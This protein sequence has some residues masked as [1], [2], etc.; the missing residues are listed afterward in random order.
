MGAVNFTCVGGETAPGV[1]GGP[2]EGWVLV[3]VGQA[4]LKSKYGIIARNVFVCPEHRIGPYADAE[5]V[6]QVRVR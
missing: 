5:V 3:R 4:R 6:T 1:N 2:P